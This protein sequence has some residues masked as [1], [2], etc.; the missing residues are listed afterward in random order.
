MA[1]GPWQMVFDS[2][3][4]EAARSADI[5]E[6]LTAPAHSLLLLARVDTPL[7]NHP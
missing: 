7:E 3:L 6:N 5:L 4:P 1:H 2:T